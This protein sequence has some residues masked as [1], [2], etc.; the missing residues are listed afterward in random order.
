MYSHVLLNFSPSAK[1]NWL[2]CQ[3]S[4]IEFRAEQMIKSVPPLP[5][6][7]LSNY[8]LEHGKVFT[9]KD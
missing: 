4:F 9:D 5:Y 6:A 1:A 7:S 8:V 3:Y 2:W